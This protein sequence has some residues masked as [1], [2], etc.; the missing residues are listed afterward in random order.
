MTYLALPIYPAS[1]PSLSALPYTG[2]LAYVPCPA[3]PILAYL[4]CIALRSLAYLSRQN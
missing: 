3:I 4:L 1:L 2:S